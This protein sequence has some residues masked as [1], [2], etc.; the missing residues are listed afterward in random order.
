MANSLLNLIAFCKKWA[1]LAI[2]EAEKALNPNIELNFLLEY[3]MNLDPV[4]VQII[5]FIVHKCYKTEFFNGIGDN[6]EK[7]RRGEVAPFFLL[8]SRTYL[9]K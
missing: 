9:N 2:D 6:Y 5:S 3:T 8:L 4:Y 7:H 1:S